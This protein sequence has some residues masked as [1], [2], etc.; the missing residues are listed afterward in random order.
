MKIFYLLAF[1]KTLLETR[2][3]FVSRIA[4]DLIIEPLNTIRGVT[5]IINF[6]VTPQIA[7]RR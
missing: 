2:L 6:T 4:S 1:P 5:V 3:K 7:C